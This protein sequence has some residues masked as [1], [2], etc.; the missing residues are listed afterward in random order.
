MQA[1]TIK[2]A[3]WVI[4]AIIIAISFQIPMLWHG[5]YN[6][7]TYNM[8]IIF[9]TV[10]Y[11]RNTFDFKNIKLHYNK[12]A[13]YIIFCFNIFLFIFILNRV[14][15]LLGFIDSMAID[16]L[17]NSEEY[18]SMSESSKLLNY[19]NAEYLLFTISS[20]AAIAAYNL[21]I[22]ISF[23]KRTKIKRERKLN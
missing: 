10:L 20:F 12:W 15:L 1:N 6:F 22:L 18:L 16:K 5:E 21:R 2:N 9:V 14:E 11:F 4:I 23:W 7:I 13:R 8:L 19:I 17:I 3:I